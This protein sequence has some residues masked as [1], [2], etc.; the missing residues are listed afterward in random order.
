MCV[1]RWFP[2]GTLFFFLARQQQANQW[3]WIRYFGNHPKSSEVAAKNYVPLL[4]SGREL[5][6]K[7]EAM[8]EAVCFLYT[9]FYAI[10]VYVTV[11]K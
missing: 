7:A 11:Y 9:Y 3:W 2:I 10:P 5:Y 1:N 8:Q 6:R 4:G